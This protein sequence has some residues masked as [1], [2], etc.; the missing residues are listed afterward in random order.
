MFSPIALTGRLHPLLVHF[1]IALVLVAAVAE[2]AA[3]VSGSR[4]WRTVAVVNLRVGAAF[5]IA[6]AVAGWLLASAVAVDDGRSLEYHRWLGSVSAVAA[7]GAALA[8]SRIDDRP[9]AV[10]WFYRVALFWAAALVGVAGH[11]GARLV[12]GADFLR[13]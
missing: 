13:P 2:L 7:I 6:T 3:T 5:A 4:E 1:P 10:R 9:T 12:W 11:L 8:T